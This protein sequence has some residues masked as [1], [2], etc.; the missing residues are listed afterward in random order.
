MLELESFLLLGFIR[1]N[2]RLLYNY[3]D[4]LERINK[5]IYKSYFKIIKNNIASILSLA[6]KDLNNVIIKNSITRIKMT[7]KIEL[8]IKDKEIIIIK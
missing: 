7:I 1:Y 4:I 5:L 2:D 3:K 6:Y 8:K